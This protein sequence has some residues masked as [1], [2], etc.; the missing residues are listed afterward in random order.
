MD[1]RAREAFLSRF[2][3]G[4]CGIGFAVLGGA[5]GEGID[6]PGDRLIG[7]FI[8][9]LG[10]PQVNAINAEFAR[11]M[12][13]QFGSGYAYTYLY[14]GIQKVIQAAGRVIRTPTDRGCVYLID[15]RFAQ[16]EIRR[17]LPRWWQLA[18]G[19]G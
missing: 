9:T 5:F 19:V 1:G 2:S 16:P 6:L 11:R 17:L 13:H 10:L 8:A 15:D 14:P 7:A 3:L 18:A 12:Q 4:G